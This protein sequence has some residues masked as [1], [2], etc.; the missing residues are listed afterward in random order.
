[1]VALLKQGIKKMELKRDVSGLIKALNHGDSTGRLL[2]V[3]AL[4]RIHDIRAVSPLI[5]ALKDR[6]DAVRATAARVLG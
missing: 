2:A 3:E 4:G 1:M 6:N 5:H